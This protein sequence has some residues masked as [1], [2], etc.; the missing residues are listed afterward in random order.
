MGTAQTVQSSFGAVR[1]IVKAGAI[2]P[3]KSA[4][5]RVI[6]STARPT[7]IV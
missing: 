7:R 6:E 5:A 1:G 4:Q 3:L 2:G